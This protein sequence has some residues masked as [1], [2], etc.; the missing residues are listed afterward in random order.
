M[1]IAF[2]RGSRSITIKY[3]HTPLHKTVAQL[4]EFFKPPPRQLGP[5]AQKAQQAKTPKKSKPEKR[6][7]ES[8][9][10]AQ[11]ENGNPKKRK[12][13]KKNPEDE[14]GPAPQDGPIMP[15]DYPGAG[16]I[17]GNT[18]AGP[19]HSNLSQ[20]VGVEGQNP[21]T[22]NDYP[23]GLIGGG[24]PANLS[25]Q[26]QLQQTRATSQAG[27]AVAVK[28]SPAEAA[29]RKAVATSLLTNAGVDPSTLSADQ[30]SIFSNQSPELQKESL[31]MLVKYG[32]ERLQMVL[33]SNREAS[34]SAT[35]STSAT[36]AQSTQP[37]PSGPTTTKELVP[38]SGVSTTANGTSDLGA[39]GA[40]TQGT[41]KT[42]RKSKRPPGKSRT[43]CFACKSRKVKV[44]TCFD[45][46]YW[47]D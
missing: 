46:R 28:V 18:Q 6:K 17:N 1:T 37:T 11:D 32:A 41:T 12:K 14:P 45:E 9:T 7:R 40:E 33:P 27:P 31:S 13:K 20:P 47:L 25:S 4:A 35:T 24:P 38:Q 44:R 23:Q 21:H 34:G 36:P 22:F 26:N 3:D 15:P 30:F 42:P 39:D 10:R 43:A 19:S 5:G 16:S 29:R 8:T 2:N